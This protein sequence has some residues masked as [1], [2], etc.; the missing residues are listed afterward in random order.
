MASAINVIF[1]RRPDCRV[2]VIT[3]VD[4]ILYGVELQTVYEEE[5]KDKMTGCANCT[6]A[7]WLDATYIS[8]DQLELKTSWH[9]DGPPLSRRIRYEYSKI[10][11]FDVGGLPIRAVAHPR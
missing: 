9:L 2:V 1:C 5:E 6:C 11:G 3:S 7:Y 4:A 8:I 10:V